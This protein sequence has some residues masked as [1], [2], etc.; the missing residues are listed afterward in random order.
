[1]TRSELVR[2]IFQKKTMLCVGLDPE[3]SKLPPHLLGLEDPVFEFCRQIIRATR[4]FCVA[5]KPNLAFFEA[6]GPAGWRTFEKVVREIGP[7]HFIIADAKRGDIGNTSRLYATA[8]FE[9]MGADALTIAPYM[10]RDSVEPF[11]GFEGKWAVV[12]GLTSNPGSQDFQLQK[13]ETGEPLFETVLR[14][15]ATWGTAENLMFVVGATQ[16]VHFQRVRAILPDH[17]FLVPGIGAQ[18]GDL[19][20]VCHAGMNAEAGL[21]INASRSIIFASAGADFAE[22]AA[23]EASKMTAQMAPFFS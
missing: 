21:L 9:K 2:H 11:L 7:D 23:A 3:I 22:A 12:L 16:T 8:F 4:P 13:L 1:M 19:E 10:G 14:K 6:L 18:G 20:S 5:F 15:T 17:F